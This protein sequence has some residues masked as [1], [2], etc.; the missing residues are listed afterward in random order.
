VDRIAGAARAAGRP[1]MIVAL[2]PE[3]GRRLIDRGFQALIVV[4]GAVLARAARNFLE[5]LRV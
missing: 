2:D 4:A 5:A 3:D 1:A